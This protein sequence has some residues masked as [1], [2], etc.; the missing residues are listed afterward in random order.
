MIKMGVSIYLIHVGIDD[1]C[2]IILFVYV[3]KQPLG[4]RRTYLAYVLPGDVLLIEDFEDGLCAVGARDI[5]EEAGC[6]HRVVYKSAGTPRGC[7]LP[8]W[9]GWPRVLGMLAL[10]S[11][12]DDKTCG[13]RTHVG[14]PESKVLG[15]RS[16]SLRLLWVVRLDHKGGVAGGRIVL[17]RLALDETTHGRDIAV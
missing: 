15:E 13:H 5:G 4:S 14:I 12:F 9:I 8:V 16:E 6:L 3:S 11:S 10:V 2:F 7:K 17:V 1:V